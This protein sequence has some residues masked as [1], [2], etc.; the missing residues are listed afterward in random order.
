MI[1]WFGLIGFAGA[2]LLPGHYYPWT[3]FQQDLFAAVATGI[4]ALA[5][6]ASVREWPVRVS[7]LAVLAVFMSLIPIVQWAAGMVPFLSDAL[8]ASAY[9]VG[10]AIAVVAGT[11]LA[12]ASAPFL[13]TLQGSIL[14]AALVS[15]G[16]CLFQWLGLGPHGLI[17]QIGPGDRVY[18]NLV[19]PNQ[20]ACLLGLGIAAVLWLYESRRIDGVGASVA[21]LFVGA[22]LVMTQSRAGWLF[23]AMYVAMW[24]LYRQRAGLRTSATAVAV[25]VVVFVLAIPMW[26]FLTHIG[27]SK[28]AADTVAQRLNSGYR[29]SHWLTVSDAV[30]RAPWLGYGWMQISV[31][32]QAATLDHAPT[33]EWLSS[34]HNQLLDLVAWNGVPLGLLMIGVM[35]WWGVR[36]MLRCRDAESWTLFVALGI[37]F[38]H[39]MVEYPLQY[40]YFLLPCG[41]F[42]GT[43]EARIGPPPLEPTRWSLGRGVFASA[44]FALAG[45]VYVVGYEYFEVEEAVRR[46]RLRDAGYVQGGVPPEVPDV[47]VLDG[48]RE[49][50]RLWL[51]PEPQRALSPS[52]LQWL[53]TV[54][55]RYATPP[56]A[57]RYALGAGLSGQSA[58]SQRMLSVMCHISQPKHCDQGRKRWAELTQVHPILASVAFPPT[59]QR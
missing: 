49:Y 31:A 45:V 29:W 16:L 53:R 57:M 58:E 42:I 36:R 15:V 6:V 35:A 34:S 56:A 44:L 48:L 46:L 30:L 52:E 10:F 8:V 2:W 4:V 3:S 32:Q 20:L 26:D 21:L 1:Y 27:E 43:I 41:L 38:T 55:R 25:G 33:Y 5:A 39:S 7:P 24:L 47:V 13:P 54:V 50:A 9:L 37:L 11:Q 28:V 14:L 12:R 18:A 23:V 17:E 59:P 51:I 22:G 40:A 19:Q